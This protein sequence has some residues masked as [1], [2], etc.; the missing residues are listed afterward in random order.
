MLIVEIGAFFIM[1]DMPLEPKILSATET[2]L[3]LLVRVPLISSLCQ[4]VF[5]T[6]ATTSLP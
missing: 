6:K 2:I 4:C 1:A 3:T 5:H